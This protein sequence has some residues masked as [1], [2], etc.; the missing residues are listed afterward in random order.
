MEPYPT[1]VMKAMD[2]ATLSSVPHE[3]LQHI[4]D[5]C[6]PKWSEKAEAPSHHEVFR[7]VTIHPSIVRVQL[8]ALKFCKASLRI[9]EVFLFILFLIHGLFSHFQASGRAGSKK[10][11]PH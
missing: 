7:H 9:R 8:F 5:F 2:D 4:I 3:L 11:T 10:Q 1:E 6:H